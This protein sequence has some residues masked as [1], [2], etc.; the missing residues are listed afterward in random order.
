MGGKADVAVLSSKEQLELTDI[1]PILETAQMLNFINVKS[2][3]VSIIENGYSIL[4]TNL[5][6][7]LFSNTA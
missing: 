3:H 2:G 4:V 7:L 6:F 1:L 5:H